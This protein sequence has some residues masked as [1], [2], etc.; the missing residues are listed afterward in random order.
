MNELFDDEVETIEVQGLEAIT[1]EV[2]AVKA[3]LADRATFI[4]G[5]DAPAIIN[6]SPWKSR[7]KLWREKTGKD[8][9]DNL[10]DV[11]RVMAGKLMEDVIGRLYTW[12]YGIKL[13]RI[14]ERVPMKDAEFP[15]AAQLDRKVE[16]LR[17]IIE[18]KNVDIS[19]KAKWGEPDSAECPVYYY[20]Q[21]EH[22]LM[23]SRYDEAEAVPFFGGN[24]VERRFVARSDEFIDNLYAAEYEFWKLVQQDIPPEPMTDDEACL[25]WTN[26]QESK[27]SAEAIAA[28]LVGY[29][30][31]GKDQIKTIKRREGLARLMLMRMMENLG[32]TLTVGGKPVCTWKPQTTKSFDLDGFR[33]AHP[34]LVA[35]YAKESTTRVFRLSKAGKETKPDMA[36][37]E[38][39]LVEMEAEAYP[40]GSETEEGADE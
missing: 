39:A 14:N 20:T 33:K 30:Q 9:V 6:V 13:R 37:V 15:A 7:V 11:E 38:Q 16:G 18:I 24:T 40:A 22:Q 19:Q 25:I 35:W 12:K 5:S 29:I 28:H 31:A 32:D 1:Q 8:P 26:P 10:D 23:C 21:I 27:V 4:G 2:E 3:D 34:E 17:K 36:M